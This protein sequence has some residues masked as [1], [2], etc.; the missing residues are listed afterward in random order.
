MSPADYVI[1]GVL[2]LLVIL[3]LFLMHRDRKSGSCAGGCAGCTANC[4]NAQKQ[5]EKTDTAE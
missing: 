4:P 5:E 2:A 1:L 3:V